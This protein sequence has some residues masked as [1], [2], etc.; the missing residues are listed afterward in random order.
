MRI[1]ANGSKLWDKTYG[2]TGDDWFYGL[3]QANE[4]GF[5]LTGHSD[6]NAT[7]DK[8]ESSEGRWSIWSV[9]IDANGSKIWDD[10]LLRN[11]SSYNRDV[12]LTNDGN[13]I[14]LS[15]AALSVNGQLDFWAVKIDGNKNKIWDTN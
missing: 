13:F 2:S 9:R 1:D 7:G 11:N 8:S 4:D 15:N 3:T 5:L 10:T 12:I 6:S 14:L